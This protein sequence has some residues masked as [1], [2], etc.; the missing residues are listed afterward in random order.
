MDSIN[1][2]GRDFGD[3]VVDACM[4]TKKNGER[5]PAVVEL[6]GIQNAGLYGCNVYALVSA[7]S[8]SPNTK[9]IKEI[10]GKARVVGYC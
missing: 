6:N 2:S 7:M 9:K 5:A 3:Y 1:G 8:Q 4:M 10:A